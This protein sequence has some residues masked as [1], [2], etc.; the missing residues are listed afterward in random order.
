GGPMKNLMRW[1][2]ALAALSGGAAF[3]QLS[4]QNITGTWQGTIQPPQAEGRGLRIVLK[5]STTAADKL[6]AVMYSIDQQSPAI[7]AT[8]FT[9]NGSTIKMT[10][11]PLNGTYEGKV[12]ADGNSI[13]GIWSQGMPLTLNLVRATPE[14]A[15]VIPEPS[16]PPK[17]MAADA[18]PGFEVATIKPARPEGRFSLTVNRSGMLNTTSTTVADLIKFAYDL[19]PRQITKGPAWLESEKYDITAKPDTEGIP[20]PTQLKLMVQ[21]L[22]KERFQLTFHNEKK[23][24]SVYAITV[25]KTGPKLTK[26]ESG[27]NLPGY[28]GG[29]GTFI[30]RNS[31]IAEF[32]HILQANILEQPVVDQTGLGATRYDFTLKWTPDPSQSQIGGPAPPNAPPP[33]DNADTPPDIFTAFQQQLGL[34]LENTKAPVDVMVVDRLEK[35]SDN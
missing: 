4:G 29:R 21:K 27:G 12:S 19:H 31:S 25:T 18:N 3:S 28:G 33:A 5:I 6:A 32:G 30:V 17:T 14:T 16:P 20:N 10:V 11:T 22:L 1:I 35:P 34:K 24:L 13:E 2:I 15:W 23:E 26:N 9:R 7:P 8:T